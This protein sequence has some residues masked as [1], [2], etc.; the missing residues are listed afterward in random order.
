MSR[1]SFSIGRL[2]AVIAL[3]AV[4]LAVLRQMES[5][6]VGAYWLMLGVLDYLIVWKGI[7]RRPLRA[8]QYT[9]FIVSWVGSIVLAVQVAMERLH[10]L[11]PI[12]RW[13]QQTTGD[14]MQGV[15]RIEYLLRVG[16]F[17]AAGLLGFLIALAA[18]LLASWL[19]GNKGWD[20]AAFWRGSLVGVVV[21]GL[22]E[23]ALRV[24]APFGLGDPGVPRYGLLAGVVVSGGLIGL[25]KLKSQC[26]PYEFNASTN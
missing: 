7:L 3:L 16:E 12:V 23:T 14:L 24:L 10:L 2:M 26:T 4:N 20:V 25:A 17:W 18:G 8:F 6:L 11:G 15:D 13:R 9:L 21:L 19:E 22:I 1:R 5:S